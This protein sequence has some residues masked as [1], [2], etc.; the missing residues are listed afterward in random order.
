M[1]R[2]AVFVELWGQQATVREP[3]GN[4]YMEIRACNEKEGD[5]WY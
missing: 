4:E 2:R 5:L 1:V 3:K